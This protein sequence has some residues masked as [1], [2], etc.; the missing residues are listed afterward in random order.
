MYF[1]R[2]PI[3]VTDGKVEVKC[4]QRNEDDIRGRCDKKI[5]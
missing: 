1:G 4:G 5:L 2:L 3:E